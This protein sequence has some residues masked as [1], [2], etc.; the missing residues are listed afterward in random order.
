MQGV[1]IDPDHAVTGE[2]SYASK[3]M[4]VIPL[5][6]TAYLAG[7]T[8]LSGG[9]SLWPGPLTGLTVER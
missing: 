4:P 2:E 3:S 1:R 9:K 5:G 6:N 7:I 8:S